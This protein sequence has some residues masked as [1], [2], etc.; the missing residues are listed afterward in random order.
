[1]GD[2]VCL[3]G[4]VAQDVMVLAEVDPEQAFREALHS[5][6]RDEW[7]WPSLCSHCSHPCQERPIPLRSAVDSPELR[8]QAT[9]GVLLALG[10]ATALGWVVFRLAAVLLGETSAG[11]PTTLA[12]PVGPARDHILGQAP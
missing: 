12:R 9:V 4:M 7:A 11:L 10:L 8:D 5:T 1:M 3:L 2:L 6:R